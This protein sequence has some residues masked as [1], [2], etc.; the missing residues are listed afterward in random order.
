ML[1]FVH[2]VFKPLTKELEDL[3]LQHQSAHRAYVDQFEKQIL[4]RGPTVDDKGVRLSNV[5]I[6]EFADR[7]A[8]DAFLVGE[9]LT[10]LGLF[11]RVVVQPFMKRYPKS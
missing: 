4:M 8:V 7:E 1:F 10:K 9:P 3:M 2:S 6:A 5:M 11:D